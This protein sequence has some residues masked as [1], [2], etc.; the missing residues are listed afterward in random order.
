MTVLLPAIISLLLLAF[1]AILIYY[2]VSGWDKIP[3]FV[4]SEGFVSLKCSVIIAARDE[5]GNI[6]NVLSDLLRQ[7]YPS[8]SFEI[9]VVNDHSSDDTT[10]IVSSFQGGNI[11]RLVNLDD[12]LSGK[13]RAVEKGVQCASGELI[14][15]VD[16]DC[17]LGRSWLS[18]IANYQVSTGS[19]LVI[20]P[21]DYP[22]S[23]SFWGKMQNIEFLSLVGI[24]AGAAGNGRPFLCNGANLAFLKPVHD[25]LL[26]PTR[27][28]ISSGDDVFLLHAMKKTDGHKISFLKS[29][30][31]IATTAACVSL[32]DFM[33]QKIR[34]ASKSKHYDDA[35]T[36]MFMLGLGGL[37]ICLVALLL[38]SLFNVTFLFFFLSLLAFKSGVD[39]YFYWKILPFFGKGKLLKYVFVADMLYVI[40]FMVIG[41]L[42]MLVKPD[43]KGRKIKV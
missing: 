15:T 17:R 9:I 34:W 14:I 6:E 2:I 16:A 35:D 8:K 37:N 12:G 19:S 29:D 5:A 27:A 4:R 42:S 33:S 32:R 10:R 21:V 26:D 7:D 25:G 28:N 41:V 18:T 13:K 11:I 38:A 24:T 40:Y 31:S 36:M 43:W 39:F 3:R 22:D 1:Y 20:C 30:E 23:A